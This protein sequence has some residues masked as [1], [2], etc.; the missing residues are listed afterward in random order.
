MAREFSDADF[1]QEE[2]NAAPA[3]AAPSREFS[4]DAF[5]PS[6]ADGRAPTNPINRSPVSAEDRAKLSLGNMPG[7]LKFLKE[8]FEDAQPD[9]DGNILVKQ[10]GLW[11]AV[12]PKGLGNVD[13]WQLTKKIVGS[14]VPSYTRD[15]AKK[16]GLEIPTMAEDGSVRDLMAA[17]SELKKDAADLYDVAVV[18]TAAGIGA[19]KGMAAA[20]PGGAIVGAGVGGMGGEAMKTSLGRLYGTYDASPEEQVS[21]IG[22]EGLFNMAGEG[23]ALGAKPGWNMVKKAFKKYGDKTT[24]YGKELLS[25]FWSD[26]TGGGETGRWAFRRAMDDSDRVV[27]KARQIWGELGDTVAPSEGIPLIQ[28]RQEGIIRRYA[29]QADDALK[30]NYRESFKG[31]IEDVPEDFAGEIGDIIRAAQQ[32]LVE[33][34]IAKPLI[35][36]DPVEAYRAGMTGQGKWLGIKLADDGKILTSAQREVMQ[37]LVD[38]TNKYNQKF[39]LKSLKGKEAAAKLIEFRRQLRETYDDLIT[40]DLADST[41]DAMATAFKSKI[42]TGVTQRFANK[43]LGERFVAANKA[44]AEKVDA[45][46]VLKKAVNAK[47]PSQA[48]DDLV[49]RL[50]SKAGSNRGLKDEVRALADLIPGEGEA[51][52][53]DLLDWEAAKSMQSIVTK[54]FQG[55]TGTSMLRTASTLAGQGN[56]RNIGRQIE[57][58]TKLKGFLQSMGPDQIDALLANDRA[59]ETLVR[60]TVSAQAGESQAIEDMLRQA[61]VK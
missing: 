13:P 56:S 2:V 60:T 4:D 11:H 1:I 22:W 61:G 34:G 31:I 53:Q 21:D 8:R 48:I 42:D 23:V 39:G 58:G 43:G 55:G 47:N 45:V 18:G 41:V 52:M 10:N 57:Y 25:T 54:T 35:A 5:L 46:K 9:K 7:K 29:S 6:Y 28:K 16:V 12:D 14:T 19:A 50:T 26:M 15:L 44:Y 27:P 40:D 49:K 17:G 37:E 33:Q 36:N 51:L 59:I 20:G 24:N 38:L 32:D 3:Q 30:R